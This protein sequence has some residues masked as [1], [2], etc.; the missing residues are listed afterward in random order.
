MAKVVLSGEG[1]RQ[2]LQSPEVL[3]DLQ[4]RADR[5]A[6]AA[7]DGFVAEQARVGAVRGRV[8]VYSSTREAMMAEASDASLTQAIDAGR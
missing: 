2:L 5:I 3:A 1:F 4:A 7:G 6:E 8:Q